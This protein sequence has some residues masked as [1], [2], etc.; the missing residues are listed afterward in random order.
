MNIALHGLETAIAEETYQER[1]P[2]LIRYA[3][4]FVLLHPNREDLQKAAEKVTEWLE[5]MGLHLHPTKTRTT[6]TLDAY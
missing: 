5:G 3:D 4:D 6:H 2:I 1:K